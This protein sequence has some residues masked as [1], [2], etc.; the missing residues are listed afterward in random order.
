CLAGRI[1]HLTSRTA[2][3]NMLSME[4]AKPLILTRPGRKPLHSIVCELLLVPQRH[5]AYALPIKNQRLLACLRRGSSSQ[6]L[7]RP[8]CSATVLILL[9]PFAAQKPTSFTLS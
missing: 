6:P 5:Y 4:T 2:S 3:T 7:P 8:S 9:S 1:V